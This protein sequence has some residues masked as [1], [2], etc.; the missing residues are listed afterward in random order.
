MITL[1]YIKINRNEIS[2]VKGIL[3]LS[4]SILGSSFWITE[5]IPF[6]IILYFPVL[7]LSIYENIGI[8]H[9]ISVFFKNQLRILLGLMLSVFI[10]IYM[11]Y[12]WISAVISGPSKNTEFSLFHSSNFFLKNG[13]GILNNGISVLGYVTG[14]NFNTAEAFIFGFLFIIAATVYATK[15]RDPL[16]KSFYIILILTVMY[17][18]IAITYPKPLFSFISLNSII[19]SIFVTINEPGQTFIFVQT[20]EFILLGIMLY[21][22][23]LYISE[24]KGH[25]NTNKKFFKFINNNIYYR[26]FIS[27][28]LITLILVIIIVLSGLYVSNAYSTENGYSTY[29]PYGYYK[30][31]NYV[32]QYIYEISNIVTKDNY[33]N[34]TFKQVLFLP[35]YY[36]ENIWQGISPYFLAFPPQNQYEIGLFQS[37]INEINSNDEIG[38]GTILSSMNIGYVAI[39]KT[40]NQTPNNAFMG[41]DNFGEPYAIFGSPKIFISYFENSPNFKLISNTDQYA[42]FKN[43]KDKGSLMAYESAFMLT[44]FNVSYNTENNN[45]LENL[46]DEMLGKFNISNYNLISNNGIYWT[47]QYNNLNYFNNNSIFITFNG[48]VNPEHFAYYYEFGF[49]VVPG[50]KILLS[51]TLHSFSNSTANYYQGFD[52]AEQNESILPGKYWQ[53]GFYTIGSDSWVNASAIFTVPENVTY[54]L[55][56]FQFMNVKGRFMVTN[57]TASIVSII[58]GS[59]YPEWSQS[60]NKSFLNSNNVINY[61]TNIG[62]GNN[63]PIVENATNMP[64]KGDFINVSPYCGSIN[65]SGIYILPMYF[66]LQKYG[67]IFNEGT[68][69]IMNPGSG[70]HGYVNVRKGIY[71][72]ILRVNGKGLGNIIINNNTYIYNTFYNNSFNIG[73]SSYL[74]SKLNIIINN[75]IGQVNIYDIVLAGPNFTN[76]QRS[77]FNSKVYSP[78]TLSGSDYFSKIKFSINTS[79]NSYILLFKE[80]FNPAWH[81][82]YYINGIKNVESPFDINGWQN[83]YLIPKNATNLTL[84]FVL[85]RNVSFYYYVTLIGTPLLLAA[86]VIYLY[87]ESLTT[88]RR[89]IYV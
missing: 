28:G 35:S 72:I 38:S 14:M 34:N 10:S 17:I 74:N 32:P 88:K 8:K 42:L 78:G 81:L 50:M 4:L 47:D 66:Y 77:I 65:Q 24:M 80:S 58:N 19:D 89:R 46:N 13:W 5:A 15:T 52:L 21:N 43:L 57:M 22:F 86:T 53:N 64:N 12:P 71:S 45:K 11:Y 33:I 54:I 82:K 26:K 69:S 73:I 2:A 40:V 60:Q 51:S 55:P 18:Q 41:Y 83:G 30:L 62:I 49:P 16:F 63:A 7:I 36:Y 3:F 44:N 79:N 68:Y 59:S 37:L 85:D 39:L 9:S 1:N 48:T 87:V 27:R 25:S 23:L 31:P 29:S 70:M 76:E 56:W 61:L 84:Y 67:Y 75:I 20:W 6:S